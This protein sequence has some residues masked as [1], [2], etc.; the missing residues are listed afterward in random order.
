MF[1]EY[2]FPKYSPKILL[3][4]ISTLIVLLVSF[5]ITLKV[6]SS[7]KWW[8]CPIIILCIITT[9]L[10]TPYKIGYDDK[11]IYIFLIKGKS[12]IP[13]NSIKS[14]KLIKSDNI[15]NSIRLFGSGGLFGYIGYFKNN[16]LG[17][18]V[19]YATST[20]QLICIE[21]YKRKYVVNCIN[22]D[23]FLLAFLNFGNK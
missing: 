2:K 21:T 1:I 12:F 6:D 5:I 20:E 16:V 4:T 10:Y 19:M 7:H 13:F 17:Y 14:I 11:G 15:S 18:Y 23:E 9:F 8:V 22:P 3:V